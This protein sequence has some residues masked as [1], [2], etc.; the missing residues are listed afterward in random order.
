MVAAM[1]AR[2]EVRL[3]VLRGLLTMFMQELTAT[4]RTPQDRLSDDE[5]TAVIRRALK[6][7][8]D[9]S[10]QFRAGGRPD[11][12]EKEESEADVLA[13]YLP[14]QLTREQVESIVRTKVAALGVTD[15]SGAGKL[16]GAVMSECKNNADGALVRDVINHVLGI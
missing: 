11:L 3:S 9:S 1:K 2:E 13:A 4:K 5:V 7:R 10:A 15:K 6:Q 12:A 8:K 14:V 16:T